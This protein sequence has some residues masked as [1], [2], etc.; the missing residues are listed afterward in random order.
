MVSCYTLGVCRHTGAHIYVEKQED[1]LLRAIISPLTLCTARKSVLS[2]F[3]NPLPD[4]GKQV[5]SFHDI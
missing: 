4:Y 2:G 1:A 5:S 3:S